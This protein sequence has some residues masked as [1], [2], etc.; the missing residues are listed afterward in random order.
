MN[1]PKLST[2]NVAISVTDTRIKGSVR[3]TPKETYTPP[4]RAI[5]VRKTTQLTPST[6]TV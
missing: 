6:L 2:P 4:T 5:P 1:S 3:K